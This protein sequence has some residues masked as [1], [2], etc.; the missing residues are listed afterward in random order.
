MTKSSGLGMA[1]MFAGYDLSGDIGVI[2]AINGGPSAI[3]VTGVDK[4]ARERL[5]GARTGH[6][7][8]TAFFNPTTNRSHDQFGNLPTGDQQVS[9]SQS[10]T[11]GAAGASMIGKQLNYDP[12]RGTDGSLTEKVAFDSN[13][14]GL[15]WGV[16]LAYALQGGAAATASLDFG[17]ASA[18]GLQA[19]LQ[20]LLFSGTS[21]TVNIQESSDNAVGDPFA[22][23]VGGGFTAAT[24]I[25]TQRIATANNLSVERYLRINTTGT[26]S[27]A[28]L[29]V[30]VMRNETAVVF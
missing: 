7:E 28:L 6:M 18:F 29:M 19:Y 22:N 17:A 11:P 16:V 21:V 30:H 13:G 10:L 8:F 9:I 20:V 4:S 12:S 24:A 1:C 3:D 23:V 2:D 27:T 5:G 15:E 14:F 25:G 26:F